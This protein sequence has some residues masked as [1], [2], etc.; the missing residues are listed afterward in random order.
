MLKFRPKYFVRAWRMGRHVDIRVTTPVLTPH[1]IRL[2][3]YTSQRCSKLPAIIY[4]ERCPSGEAVVIPDDG[5]NPQFHTS[6]NQ[7]LSHTQLGQVN[8]VSGSWLAK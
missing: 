6:P 8:R 7:T 4:N 2:S 1:I 5:S 3:L